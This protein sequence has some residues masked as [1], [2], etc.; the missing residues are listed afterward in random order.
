M[1]ETHGTATYTLGQYNEVSVAIMRALPKVLAGTDP[2]KVIKA[3]ENGQALEEALNDALLL[4]LN[5]KVS[6]GIKAL[7][8]LHPV[9]PVT[10]NYD[11]SVEEA[12]ALG[13]YDHVFPNEV[14]S[15]H[16]KTERNGIAELKIT[17]VC[18]EENLMTKEIP[19]KLDQLGYRPAELHELL[20]FGAKY[21]DVQRRFPI[22]A[23]GSIWQESPIIH[24]S[25]PW[26]CR[27]GDGRA[28]GL[29]SL[30][31]YWCGRNHF[32]AVHK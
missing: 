21:P 26:I 29:C 7:P 8:K 28:L 19:E 10:V 31:A 3:V 16:F 1:S 23:L 18:I 4:L 15:K 30:Q 11:L 9:Y 5:R 13:K 32:A 24:R 14:S 27:D 12:V 22:V 2:K 20:A 17:L 25:I 6:V